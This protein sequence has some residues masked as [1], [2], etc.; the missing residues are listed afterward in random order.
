MK[1]SS[2]AKRAAP[3]SS[4]A[5]APVSDKK[6]KSSPHHHD[7]SSA[8]MS[9]FHTLLKARA[10][11]RTDADRAEAE[12]SL[13]AAGGMARYQ[14]LSL[15]GVDSSR[16]VL[17][18]LKREKGACDLLDVGAIVH[19]YPGE[20]EGMKL[21]VTSID[22]HSQDARVKQIDFFEFAK[23]SKTASFDAVVLSLVINFVPTPL[24]RGKMLVEAARLLRKASCLF[25]PFFFFLNQLIR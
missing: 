16:F 18:R 23:K 9:L 1:K 21:R 25:S 4:P 8:E 20:S 17:A 22:L 6:K 19:R 11:A 3:S 15:Q 7:S 2:S 10:S 24:E 12:S 5:T 13:A 14:E